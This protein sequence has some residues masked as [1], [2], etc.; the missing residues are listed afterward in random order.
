[1]DK[2]LGQRQGPLVELCGAGVTR[3]GAR[4]LAP[5]DF[6]L[7]P[8]ARWAVLGANGA[9][10]TTFLRLLRGEVQP[11]EGGLRA[12]DFPGAGGPQP[13]PLGLRQRLG[14]VSGDMQDA[15]AA[16]GWTASGLDV[17]LSGFGD[18][19]LL[20]APPEPEQVLAAGGLLDALGLSGLAGRRM[21]RLSTGEARRLLLARALVARPDVLVLDEC[22]EG[23]DAPARKDFLA[24]LDRAAAADPRLAVLFATHRLDELP[25]CLTHALVLGAGRVRQRGTLAEVLPAL[26]MQSEAAAVRDAPAPVPMPA[27]LPARPGFLARITGACVDVGGVRLLHE[28]DWTILPGEHWAVL[29]P[30]G[31][32]KSTLLSLLSGLIWPSAVDKAPG[33]VEYGFA[34]PAGAPGPAVDTARRRVGLVSAAL[35][36]FFPYDLRVREAVASG[37]D[38][39]LDVFSEPDAAGR[40]RVAQWL[41]FFGLAE[42]AERRIRSLSRGQLRRVLLA[43]SVTGNPALLVLDEPMAGLDAKARAAVRELFDRLAALGVPLVMVTHHE[44]DLPGRINR[45]LALRAGR[46]AFCGGREAYAGWKAARRAGRAFPKI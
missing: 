12:Y 41:D 14:L 6:R 37:L 22:L 26:V 42:L 17:V 9:G 8:G 39:N 25:G 31:A 10:K 7:E 15:F 11:D 38:G 45:V 40:A 34:A 4:L 13:T 2:S 24:L 29:G 32:G 20:Y 30:N 16:H 5:L 46:V 21:A 3:A 19:P 33:L 36:A 28:I 35:Q 44:A 27:G 43:R 1:M 18:G 23:L